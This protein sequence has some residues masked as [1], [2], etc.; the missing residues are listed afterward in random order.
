MVQSWKEAYI[1]VDGVEVRYRSQDGDI[2]EYIRP[3]RILISI[4][5]LGVI[6]HEKAGCDGDLKQGFY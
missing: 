2:A 4:R 1:S 5:T 3:S 6:G